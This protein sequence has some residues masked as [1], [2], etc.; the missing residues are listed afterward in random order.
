[1]LAVRFDFVPANCAVNFSLKLPF[2]D[3]FHD[4]AG[5]LVHQQTFVSCVLSELLKLLVG[6][7]AGSKTLEQ[8]RRF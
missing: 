1:M 6:I 8:S 7:I 3:A 4:F 2:R 5:Q